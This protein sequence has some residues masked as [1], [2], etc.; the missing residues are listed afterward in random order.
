MAHVFHCQAVV[1]VG[2]TA[3]FSAAGRKGGN[4]ASFLRRRSSTQDIY[5]HGIPWPITIIMG[6]YIYNGYIPCYA[7]DFP[8]FF[9]WI[10]SSQVLIRIAV[11]SQCNC[12]GHIFPYDVP[13]NHF[14][15]LSSF[16]S[17]E[18]KICTGNYPLVNKHS[19][20]KLPF[21]VD[22]PIKNGEFP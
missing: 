5:T 9:F 17:L 7:V 21:I 18:W 20:W 22:L 15:F 3:M 4:G 13:I 19:Y 16:S 11:E 12:C 6:I 2:F 1:Q 14:R 8:C 10:Y